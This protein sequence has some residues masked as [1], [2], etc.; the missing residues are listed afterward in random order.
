MGDAK[1]LSSI[2]KVSA[3][4]SGE[5]GLFAKNLSTEAEIGYRCD[6]LMPT[7]SVIKVCVL[8][9]L[10][11]QADTGLVDLK[12][13]IPMSTNDWSGGSGILREFEPGLELTITD[14]ARAMI[15][16][17]DNVATGMLVRLLGKERINATLREWG[18][19]HTEL[20]W[21]MQLGGDTRQ[22]ALSTPRE[23]GRL[24]EFIATDAIVT[25]DAC[26]AMRDHLRRQQYRDQIPRYL[27]FNPYA[28]DLGQPQ[29]VSIANKTGFYP[30]VRA[31][32][33]IV[34]TPNVTFVIATMTEGSQDTGFSAEHEGN[35]LNGRVARLV[36]DAWVGAVP[37]P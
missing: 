2:D 10:Y 3:G 21:S 5:L 6:A 17:S 23:L 4:F 25:P 9:E 32:A 28:A 19:H 20:I 35:V 30:G 7:A 27:P 11:R 14:L 29:L 36:F 26:A 15:V 33:A 8:A 18:L 1:R 13:R 22:Y 12:R 24:M 31:D 16:V 37:E 34:E